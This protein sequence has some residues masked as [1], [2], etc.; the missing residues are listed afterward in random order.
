M[1]TS[2]L[3]SFCD[4]DTECLLCHWKWFPLHYQGNALEETTIW[5]DCTTP[6]FYLLATTCFGSSLQSSGSLL[7]PPDLLEIQ[8]IWVVY[9]TCGYMTCVPDCHGSVCCH[10]QNH[11][12]PAHRSHNHTLYTTHL[13]CISSNSG[14]SHKIPDGSRLLPKM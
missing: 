7:D 13:I 5:T 10:T 12:N 2:Q 8:I 14:G 3:T 11:N 9:H 4:G 1:I 6:L